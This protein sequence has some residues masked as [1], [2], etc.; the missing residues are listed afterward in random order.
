MTQQCAH[1]LVLAIL[2]L[3]SL[4]ICFAAEI[5]GEEIKVIV[6]RNVPVPM[7]DGTILRADVH[8]PDRGGPYPVLVRRTPYGKGGNFSQFVEAG[9]IVVSQDIRGRFASE[10]VAQTPHERW[11]DKTECE[12][13]YD[14]VEWAARL[15]NSTGK[16]GTFGSST[17][18]GLQWK[19]AS[20]AP[21]SLVA[22][23]ARSMLARRSDQFP[24]RIPRPYIVLLARH[25]ISTPERLRRSN[26]PGVHRRWEAQKL[27]DEGGS[28]KWINFLP[29]ADFPREPPREQ[30]G[31]VVAG[32][33]YVE[34]KLY[35]GCKDIVVPNLEITGWYDFCNNDILFFRTMVSEAKTQVAREGSRIIIG[36]WAHAGTSRRVSSFDFGPNAEFDVIAAQI[37]WFDYWLKGIQNEVDKDP[38]VRIFVMGDNEW[39][40]EQRWP[41]ERVKERVLFITSGGHANTP[42]GDGRLVQQEPGQKGKDQYLYDPEDPVRTLFNPESHLYPFDLRPLA[43]REDI[44]VYQGDPLAERMEVTGNA[45]V[46]LYASSSAPDTDWFVKLIDVDPNGLARNISEGVVRARY[47]LGLDKAEF[48]ELD[49]VV[50]YTI[51]MGPTSNAF[52]PGHR[53]RLDITSSDFPNY[54][55][56]H[57]TATDQRVDAKLVTANQTIYHG[58]EQTTRIILP[59]VP[60]PT[61]EE[62]LTREERAKPDLEKQTDP[63]TKGVNINAG[64]WTDLHSAVEGG[65]NE[66][67]ELLIQE[68]IDIDAKN[69]RGRTPL[70]IA[71]DT[72]NLEMVE[73][74]IDRGADINTKNNRG[75][76]PLYR[77]IE[78]ERNDIAELLIKEGANINVKNKS[79]KTPLYIA[80]NTN[81]IKM[82]EL[83]IDRGADINDINVENYR[84]LNVLQNAAVED[85]ADLIELLLSKGAEV[86]ERG[87]DKYE[88]TA[89]HYAARFGTTKVAEVLMAHGANIKAK[90]KWDYQ[91]IH[92]AAYHDR[93]DIIQLLIDKGTD[94][95]AKTSLGQT[96]LELAK[97]RR[98]TAAIEVLLKHGAHD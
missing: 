12:D 56:N 36:P 33:R 5:P 58:G 45:V 98:N 94:V 90:D 16:V 55:R 65:R 83:L 29:L 61:E 9:Y 74:L 44:L 30:S 57:N 23:V 96:P 40:N 70:Y 72:N 60:N 6:E 64:P 42:N 19:L 87:D 32:D 80:A 76:T 10:G 59:W 20:F 37:R 73:L 22:M 53:I 47:R 91:P 89:L 97:P 63:L 71:V 38:P 7:R 28:E 78:E 67:A 13:G 49:E 21:P 62:K 25:I 18:A 35:E 50:K 4:S 51:R 2:L 1:R 54:D 24:S 88:F 43:K 75:K 68:N 52:L 85:C 17:L 34:W 26:Y 69:D 27:W 41:L 95:N 77:A 93:P 39:R 92:W 14:T 8:R 79:G 31:D 46:E 81:N 66:I 84:G 11:E 15:P 82:V 48:I 3:S 86:D